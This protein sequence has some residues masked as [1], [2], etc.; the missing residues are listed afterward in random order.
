MRLF[1]ASRVITSSPPPLLSMVL[2]LVQRV[3]LFE[4]SLWIV[5]YEMSINTIFSC[6]NESNQGA[7]PAYHTL[8][9]ELSIKG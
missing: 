2:L 5:L 1:K 7:S 6:H 4:V 3:E 9:R 8:E